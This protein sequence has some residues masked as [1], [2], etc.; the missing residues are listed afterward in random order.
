MAVNKQPIFSASGDIKSAASNNAGVVVGPSALTTQDGSGTNIFQI[1]QAGVDGAYVQKITFRAV[2]SPA[3]TVARIFINSTIGA[4]AWVGGTTNTTTNTWL[5]EE[6]SL[7]AITLSQT[8]ASPAFTLD[9]NIA[10]PGGASGG[11]R[12]CVGFGTSTGAAGT[13]YSVVAVA[14]SYTG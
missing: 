1:F 6:I 10:L 14:G 7:P 5:Y 2:G 9:L 8:V 13:G 11:Y 12:L 3:A 4:G